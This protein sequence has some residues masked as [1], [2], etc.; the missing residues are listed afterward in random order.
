MKNSTDRTACKGKEA[1]IPMTTIRR[2]H[3]VLLCLIMLEVIFLS[4]CAINPAQVVNEIGVIIAGILPIV[5]AAGAI[6]FPGEAAAITAAQGLVAAG[7]AALEKLVND[8][9]ANP[10][11]TTLAKVTAAMA[12][13][14]AN[15]TS[16]EQAAAIKNAG[17]QKKL[18]AIITGAYQSLALV[19]AQMQAK[20]PAVV[21]AA[22]TRA[23]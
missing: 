20:H 6:L 5:A 10:S 14:Q 15:L 21:A 23:A 8:Y 1:K 16:L 2:G 4:G 7:V 11:D 17:L 19:E 9:Q 13:L 12:D 22:A 3:I 18:L